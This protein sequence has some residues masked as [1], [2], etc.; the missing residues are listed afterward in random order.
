MVREGVVRVNVVEEVSDPPSLPVATT[1]RDPVDAV[2]TV[3]VQLNPPVP[4]ALCTVQVC[5]GGAAPLK[6]NVL[7]AAPGV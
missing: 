4:D 3:N 7:M 1:V 6:V 2:G 5:V